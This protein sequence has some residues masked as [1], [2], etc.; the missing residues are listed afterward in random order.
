MQNIIDQSHIDRL[1]PQLR[2]VFD[3]EIAAGNHT[4][5][6]RDGWPDPDNLFV[7]LSDPFHKEFADANPALFYTE[8]TPRAW[9]AHYCDFESKQI[10]ACGFDPGEHGT[11]AFVLP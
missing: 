5:G 4:V 6:T 10:L 8:I 7:L 2:Q 1:C 11:R 3:A 9:K